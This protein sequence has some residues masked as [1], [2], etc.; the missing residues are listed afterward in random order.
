MK[1]IT[2]L[3]ALLAGF[4]GFSQSNRQTIQAYLDANKAKY[5]LTAADVAD[6][7]IESE[8]PGSGTGI[9]STYIVQR[10][11]GTEIFNAQ[12]NVWVKNGAVINMG[13]N[14]KSNIAGKI[15]T[16]TPSLT[17]FQALSSAYTNLGVTKSPTFTISETINSKTFKISDGLQ[18]DAIS[19]KLVYQNM[20]DNKLRLAWGFQFYSP[21]SGE[22]WDLRIDALN[23]TI[24]EKINLTISCNFGDRDHLMTDKTKIFSF[25]KSILKNVT[26]PLVAAPGIAGKY[27]VIPYNFD[28][29]NHSPFQIIQTNGNLLASPNGWHDSNSATGTTAALKYTYTRGNNVLAQEDAIGDNETTVGLRPSGGSNLDF[30]AFTYGFQSALPTSYTSAA[31]TNLF[32]MNNIMHD[33]WYQ[34]GFTE[35]SGNF[36]QNN[37]G[38]QGTGGAVNSATG[39]Y[40]LA[41]AQDGYSQTTATLN[42]ANFSTPNDGSRP[43]M[44]M[45]L[46]NQGAPPTEYLFV[47]SPAIIAGPRV[48]TQNVFEGIDRIAIPVAPDGIVRDLV[49]YTNVPVNP[50]QNPNS[51]CAAATNPF[52]LTDKIALVKRGGCFFKDKVKNA[53][54]AGAVAVIVTDTIVNNPQ[55]LSMSSTGLN[56]ITIPAVFI[57]KESG[58]ELIAQLLNGPV[59]IKL[60]VPQNLYLYAD[61]DFENGII[62]H[63]YGHGIS[64]KLIGGPVNSSCMT[65]I[66]QMGEGWSDWFSLMMQLKPGQQGIDSVPVG[67]YAVN[68]PNNGGGIRQFPYTTDMAINP[69]TL[70]GS[71]NADNTTTGYRYTIGEMWATVMWDLTWAYIGKYG[72]D[73]NI[74][75]GVGGNNKVMR[76]V[77][78]ALKL[79]ACNTASFI[80]SRD[81]L[82]AA[83][84]AT[85]GGAD[86]CMIAEVFRRR[87]LGLNA[88]SGDINN[89]GDQVEDFTPFPAGP[90]CTLAV[91]YF[92]NNEMFRVSPN[93]SNGLYNIRINNFVGKINLEIVDINGR[94]IINDKNID[95]NNEKNIDLSSVQSGVYILKISGENINYSQKLIKN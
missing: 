6:W 52:D 14:F 34:Y 10:Y 82:F 22:L 83:D 39:D 42:N 63:E 61:C 77:L 46:W 56:G 54:L 66:E 30:T 23:G 74:Y 1:K 47:N 31:T 35:A 64:N 7:V 49:L 24:L 91:N 41:D 4:V 9:T 55:R 69:L 85:T 40:V 37:L 93:P 72:Y 53:Q 5:E 59:N 78:D 38:R 28:S 29:P 2:L 73:D 27:N 70:N 15:N 68:E 20:K 81:L 87:G 25:E 86:Y 11:Q 90:N 13:N 3:T 17:V 60:E 44:Q 62:G 80:S 18:E 71:N 58:D 16:T 88:S 43:R 19:S 79:Q 50:T 32:Y 67:T 65:N 76:L 75:T 8:V 95:F 48:A 36:Q 21:T 94:L 26:K 84:Q 57:S 45:F 51:A 92:E 12:N 89:S 33:V